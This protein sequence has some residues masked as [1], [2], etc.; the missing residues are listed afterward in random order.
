MESELGLT[1]RRKTIRTRIGG[2]VAGHVKLAKG[3]I[4]P[5]FRRNKE[6]IKKKKWQRKQEAIVWAAIF[7]KSM[8]RMLV[9]RSAL[10]GLLKM[11]WE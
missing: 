7:T 11:Q 1:C 5:D 8:F 9:L 6:R 3:Q 4:R 10:F 2:G